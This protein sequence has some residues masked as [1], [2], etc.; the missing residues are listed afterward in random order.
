MGMR[1]VVGARAAILV[2]VRFGRR[3]GSGEELDER[4]ERRPIE[5]RIV[6]LD[7]GEEGQANK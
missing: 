7:R 2:S 5:K 3:D 1:V 4:A 6:I